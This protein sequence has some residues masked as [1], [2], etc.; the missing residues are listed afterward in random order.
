MGEYL[1]LIRTVIYSEAITL[2]TKFAI[3]YSVFIVVYI[4]H[5]YAKSF[6]LIRSMPVLIFHAGD[7]KKFKNKESLEC[8]VCLC[9][10]ADGEKVRLLPSCNHG[11]HVDCIDMW[12]K[13]HSTCPLCRNNRG[14]FLPGFNLILLDIAQFLTGFCWKSLKEA[15]GEY[16]EFIRT[17]IYSE[18]IT[19]NSKFAILYS[20]FIV[21]YI[22]HFYAKS[23]LL[24]RSMPVLIFHADDNK[25][26][27]NK[28]SLECAVCLCEVA[29]GEKVRLLPNCSHGFHVDCIDMWFKSHSTCPLCRNNVPLIR[30]HQHEHSLLSHHISSFQNLFRRIGNPLN[31]EIALALCQNFKYIS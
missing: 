22:L 17:V 28:G 14:R 8:A 11:F 26:F 23:F 12:F 6:W 25:K 31:F 1:E 18:A 2:N 30:Q 3:L 10:V 27:K 19:T 21:V 9:E 29:D 16:L 13:S 20:V 15:M 24:I 5:F 7:N 4:L